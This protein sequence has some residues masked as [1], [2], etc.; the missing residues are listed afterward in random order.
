[1]AE[2]DALQ[3][4]LIAAMEKEVQTLEEEVGDI[5]CGSSS[6]CEEAMQR[7]ISDCRSGAVKDDPDHYISW[8]Y[9]QQGRCR[10]NNG[11]V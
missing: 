10:R 5:R 9:E 8:K 3:E 1:M 6:A 7:L 11:C 4:A 2:Y